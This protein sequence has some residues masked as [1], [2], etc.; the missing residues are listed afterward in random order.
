MT[1]RN[2]V[3]KICLVVT[4]LI[5]T[6]HVNPRNSN[7]TVFYKHN[8]S[9]LLSANVIMRIAAGTLSSSINQEVT[10]LCSPDLYVP[11]LGWL[12]AYQCLLTS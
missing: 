10:V 2:L 7:K 12:G 5:T 6:G 11:F 3:H 1:C 9:K 8:S 4:Q